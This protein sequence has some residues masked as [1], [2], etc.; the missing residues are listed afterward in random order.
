[1]AA[2]GAALVYWFPPIA[3][4]LILIAMGLTWWP[5]YLDRKY[6]TD[7]PTKAEIGAMPKE[8]Y[9]RKIRNPKFRQWV[10][11]LRIKIGG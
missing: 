6:G 11:D 8:E 5:L 10:E 1:M 4:I 7:R 3:G 9:R 2:V